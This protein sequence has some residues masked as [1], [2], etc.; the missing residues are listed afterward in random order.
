MRNIQE[1]VQV[2]AGSDAGYIVERLEP[3]PLT[4]STADRRP[5]FLLYTGTPPPLEFVGV[6]NLGILASMARLAYWRPGQAGGQLNLTLVGG[7]NPI[8]F[9]AARLTTALRSRPDA[10]SPFPELTFEEHFQ[11]LPV[12][13]AKT[14]SIEGVFFERRGGGLRLYQKVGSATITA[15]GAVQ[16]LVTYAFA[17]IR[18]ALH[19]VLMAS[20]PDLLLEDNPRR[21]GHGLNHGAFDKLPAEDRRKIIEAAVNKARRDYEVFKNQSSTRADYAE[22]NID[23]EIQ[24]QK[25]SFRFADR[26]LSPAIRIAAAQTSASR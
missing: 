2:G 17:A 24:N 18:E 5:A 11:S 10:Q 23:L 20:Y 21:I 7:G 6:E 4:G 16:E 1:A 26:E 22:I 9:D 25:Q 19:N 12:A 8:D 15:S 13:R 14:L 3:S